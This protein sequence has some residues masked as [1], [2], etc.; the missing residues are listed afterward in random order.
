MQYGA[1]LSPLFLFHGAN[2]PRKKQTDSERLHRS[3][4][5]ATP[6]RT[7]PICSSLV[8]QGRRTSLCK[9][10]GQKEVGT[11]PSPGKCSRKTVTHLVLQNKD[12]DV[13]CSDGEH[14]ERHHLEDDQRGGD[15]D[16][17]V[18]AHGGE[19]GT[20]HHQDPTQTHQKLGVHLRGE[21]IR[22]FFFFFLAPVEIVA[23]PS[24][25]ASYLLYCVSPMANK[26]TCCRDKQHSD[27]TAT[28]LQFPLIAH[29][30]RAASSIYLPEE[31]SH[32][33]YMKHVCISVYT[34]HI[35]VYMYSTYRY[36]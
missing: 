35:C 6:P 21:E 25:A 14:E 4:L 29:S 34:V 20:A 10:E 32:N 33:T 19:D 15:A 11:L 12:E 13:V 8:S 16:P 36:I 9:E 17:G 5:G 24:A 27:D 7:R 28:L 30:I 26:P 31:H 18:E 1:S 3:M 2:V 22:R 23:V